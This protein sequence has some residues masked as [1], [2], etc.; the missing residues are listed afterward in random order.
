MEP[1]ATAVVLA[2]VGA[3]LLLGGLSSGPSE[4][5]GVP[6]L[7]L[8][9]VLGM[10]AGSEGLGGIAFDDYGRGVSA[11]HDRARAHPLRRRTQ[12]LRPDDA[13]RGGARD[14][15]GDDRRDRHGGD[16]RRRVRSWSASRRRF[17]VLV[18]SVVLSPRR[19]P[20]RCSRCCAGGGVRL[21]PRTAATLEVESGL[22][23]PMAIV[24][25]IVATDVVL[26][27][28][29]LDATIGVLLLQQF[30]I[31]AVGGAAH[32]LARATHPRRHGPARAG[33]LPRPHGGAGVRH[34]RRRSR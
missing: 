11:G 2:A 31:G 25:T 28:Q 30:G 18:G 17:A 6:T 10:A 4:R 9:L 20:P 34:L 15:A 32:G 29:A 8:F 13:P 16:R 19:T 22:N 7:L 27:K 12:H 1:N 33:A 3:L 21:E 14:R 5:L 24:L 26:G 23:D